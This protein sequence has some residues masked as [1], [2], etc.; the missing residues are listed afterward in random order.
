MPH[1]LQGRHF[2]ISGR[3][4]GVGFRLATQNEARNLG[5]TGWGRNLTDGRVEVQAFGTATALDRL[6]EWLHRG[7]LLARVIDV[8]AQVIDV[9][10]EEEAGK[11]FILKPTGPDASR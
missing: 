10:S 6:Q 7:P 11:E 8:T 1:P 9:C 5:L 4:Q 3:V 2:L